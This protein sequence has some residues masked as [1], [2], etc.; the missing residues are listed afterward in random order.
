[1]A[2]LAKSVNGTAIASLG[3]DMAVVAA[4]RRQLNIRWGA[5]LAERAED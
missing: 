3:G 4:I 2:A 5:M 1:M